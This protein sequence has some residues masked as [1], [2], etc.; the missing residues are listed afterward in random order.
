M[1]K[2]SRHWIS[3]PFYTCTHFF[4]WYIFHSKLNSRK[5]RQVAVLCLHAVCYIVGS[6]ILERMVEVRDEN[7][8]CELDKISNI[9]FNAWSEQPNEQMQAVR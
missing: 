3:L 5:E 1:Q 9:N 6:V 7:G 8:N 2:S 4:I